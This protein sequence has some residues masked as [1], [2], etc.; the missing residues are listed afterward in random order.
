MGELPPFDDDEGDDDEY[1]GL[2]ALDYAYGDDAA[3]QDSGL[4]AFGE[5]YA[6]GGSDLPDVDDADFGGTVASDAAESGDFGLAA[7]DDPGDEDALGIPLFA[8]TNPP[9]TVTVTAFMDGRVQQIELSPKVLGMTEAD[10]SD[11]IV[12]IADLAAQDARSAQYSV[13]LDGMREQGHDDFATRDFLTREL[14]LPTPEQA[15]SARAEVF[16]TRYGVDN[17]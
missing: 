14:Q 8:V 12:V 15:D 17:G 10:L 11:E 7:L 4:D 9:G 13:M 2:S 5:S 6:T 1:Q 16:T 3:D